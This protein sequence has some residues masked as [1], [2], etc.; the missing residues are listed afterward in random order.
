M[1]LIYARMKYKDNLTKEWKEKFSSL[2][3]EQLNIA[4]SII[5]ANDFSSSVVHSC[6]D[7]DV[8]D[9]LNYYRIRRS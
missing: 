7:P 4:K 1:R 6:S 9:V 8:V 3:P 5:A 2:N